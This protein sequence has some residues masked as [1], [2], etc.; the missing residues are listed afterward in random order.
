MVRLSG[1]DR[2]TNG[3]N[4]GGIITP[5]AG[6]RIEEQDLQLAA[7]WTSV[8]SPGVISETRLMG[9]T[10][11]FDQFANSSDPGVSRPGGVFGG[12]QLNTQ[13]REEDRI[14]LVQ[15]MTWQDNNHTWKFGA[16]ATFSKTRIHTTFNPTGNFLYESDVA[17]EPG[18]CT[19]L[20]ANCD[21][22]I[23][24]VRNA[25]FD[26]QAED[27][28][29]TYD[30]IKFTPIDLP[31]DTPGVDDDGDG[32]ID[33]GALLGTYPF[34]Y[35]LVDGQPSATMDDNIYGLFFQDSWQAS[36]RFHLDYGLRYDLRTYV[37]PESARVDSAIANGGAQRD[38]DNIA[39]RVGFSYSALDS[40]K[41]I[42]RGGAGVF[43]DKLVLGFPAVASITSGMEIGMTFPQGLTFEFTDEILE[44]ALDQG[45]TMDEI[46]QGLAFQP[47]LTL[48]FSTGTELQTPYA[49]QY[50]LGADWGVGE[51]GVFRV[52]A[53]HVL[54]YHQALLRDLNPV[55][56]INLGVPVHRDKYTGICN[57]G[58]PA[59]P[60]CIGSIAA[61]VT[62]GRSWYTGL[63]LG[64]NWSGSRGRYSASYTIARAE[65]MGFDPLKGGIA[66][67]PDSDNI[68]GERGRTDADRRHRFVLYGE[69]G[70]PWLDLRVSGVMQLASGSAF[71]VTTGVDDNMDGVLSDRPAGIG[72]NTGD[73][74][75]LTIVNALREQYNEERGLELA[76]ITSLN[77]PSFA[78]FDV[79]VWKVMPFRNGSG[80]GEVFVQIFNVFDRF[81][82]GLIEGRVISPYFG[83]PIAM[84]GPSRTFQLGF[85]LAF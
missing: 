12:N 71:N 68:A 22:L 3:L 60:D 17:F 52:N 6:F 45:I 5:E 63:D 55:D 8:L 18:D 61:F 48:R 4:V 80:H 42:F 38:D 56:E 31:R 62:E 70:L 50:H 26:A 30:E 37:L 83:R 24:D 54:G 51:K 25:L 74:T 20:V 32:I 40:G 33:E 44:E 53:S 41:L 47:E 11:V 85:K 9:G 84:A 57:S 46:R 64:W 34:V 21:L 13:F 39:P 15:N 2:T 82:V 69:T 10:S 27:P 59:I 35:M 58:D 77:D 43:Y 28:E 19:P 14:Q 7:T 29:A 75:D 72:R 79:R 67:P 16:D 1:D 66:L 81:N 23:S 73:E 76:P 36:P 49:V 65:D 78:Q